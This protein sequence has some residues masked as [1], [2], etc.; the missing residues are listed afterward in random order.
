MKQDLNL[1]NNLKNFYD[2]TFQN[3]DIAIKQQNKLLETFIDSQP[4]IYKYTLLSLHKEWSKNCE[5]ALNDYKDMLFK[6]LDYM[7]NFCMN[8]EKKE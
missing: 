5:K 7:S 1:F 4:G 6:G 3:M 8:K 2:I